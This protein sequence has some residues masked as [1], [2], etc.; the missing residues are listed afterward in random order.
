MGLKCFSI[1]CGNPGGWHITAALRQKQNPAPIR[2]PDARS[3]HSAASG[4]LRSRVPRHGLNEEF[5]GTPSE[6]P[7]ESGRRRAG[8]VHKRAAVRRE[9]RLAA[10]AAENG[11]DEYASASALRPEGDLRPVRRKR[12]V[13]VARRVIRN[14]IKPLPSICWTQILPFLT[15]ATSLPSVEMAASVVRPGLF[16]RRRSVVSGGADGLGGRTTSQ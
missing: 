9:T 5:R 7:C 8:P 1:G 10:L 6:V 4:D 3:R 15:Y 14:P 11:C 12:R 13:G 2:R 16:V